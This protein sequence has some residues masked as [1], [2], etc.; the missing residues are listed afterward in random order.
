MRV[1]YWIV[2]VLMAVL[3]GLSGVP[4]ILMIKE[5]VDVF[6]H[7]GYPDYILPFIGVAKVLGSISV[8]QPWFPRLREWAYAGLAI[9][10]VGAAYSHLSV[11]DGLAG[12]APAIVAFVLVMISYALYRRIRGGSAGE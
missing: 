1:A 11:G 10:V 12:A 6:R 4:D 5:A 8:L 9:D 3:L 7:L 2:T